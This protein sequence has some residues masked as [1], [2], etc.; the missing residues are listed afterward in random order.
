LIN[1][2]VRAIKALGFLKEQYNDVE[3][4]VEDMTIRNMYVFIFRQLL[5]ESAHLSVR[6]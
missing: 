5:G 3:I 4:Y 2:S 6:I 1:Y